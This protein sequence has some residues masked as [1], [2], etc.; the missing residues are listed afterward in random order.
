MS[1]TDAPAT[2][3]LATHCICCGR[4]LLDAKSVEANIGPDC[5]EKYGLDVE[6]PTGARAKANKLIHEAATI[7]CHEDVDDPA[8]VQRILTIA[9]EIAALGLPGVGAKVAERFTKKLKKIAKKCKIRLVA[10]EEPEAR[11][12]AAQRDQIVKVYTPYHRDFAGKARSVIPEHCLKA[13]YGEP[14]PGYRRGKFSH[15]EVHRSANV[16][17]LGVLAHCFAGQLANGAKGP[18]TVPTVEEARNIF[19]K[20]QAAQSRPSRAA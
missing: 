11:W 17:L 6:L 1:Y 4:P 19:R 8:V 5:R 16:Y 20:W 10:D 7:A 18:F 9:T 13:V 15:W 3:L 14:N 12:P 2:G